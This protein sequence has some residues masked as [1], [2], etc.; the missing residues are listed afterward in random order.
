MHPDLARQEQ[1]RQHPAIPVHRDFRSGFDQ[2]TAWSI[3]RFL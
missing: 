3:N 1:F 2:A